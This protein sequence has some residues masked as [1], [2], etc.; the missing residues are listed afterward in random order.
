LV[1][2]ES[3]EVLEELS[4][5]L[6]AA[7]GASKLSLAR[8]M[9]S[10]YPS[11]GNPLSRKAASRLSYRTSKSGIDVEEEEDALSSGDADAMKGRTREEKAGGNFFTFDDALSED[12]DFEIDDFDTNME[13]YMSE[14]ILAEAA[15]GKFFKMS[16]PKNRLARRPVVSPVSRRPPRSPVK[17]SLPR[18]SSM[19]EESIN[20]GSDYHLE[21]AEDDHDLAHGNAVTRK[22]KRSPDRRLAPLT[23]FTP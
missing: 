18:T 7:S 6:T 14:D 8:S 3:E 17:K 16:T 22:T 5:S 4:A 19:K 20:F 23:P 10:F 13:I 12:S 11:T 9:R 2:H 21:L 1:A 15:D